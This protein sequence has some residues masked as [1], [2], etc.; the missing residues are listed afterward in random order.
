MVRCGCC[1]TTVFVTAF[2]KVAHLL[3]AFGQGGS[4]DADGHAEVFVLGGRPSSL[5][6][7]FF[8]L[9]VTG[10]YVDV[11]EWWD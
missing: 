10:C 7:W 5:E 9:W 2:P 3:A 8:E 6:F 1:S 11:S 4:F